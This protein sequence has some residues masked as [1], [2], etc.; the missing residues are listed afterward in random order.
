MQD[1]AEVA[2]YHMLVI[3]PF[4]LFINF[5]RIYVFVLK[6]TLFGTVNVVQN[7]FLLFRHL[8]GLWTADS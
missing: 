7:T 1:R 5:P 6:P 2:R 3:S 8:G 4:S